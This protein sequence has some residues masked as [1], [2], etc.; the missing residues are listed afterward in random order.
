M[1][2]TIVNL[3]FSNP[4]PFDVRLEVVGEEREEFELDTNL[5]FCSDELG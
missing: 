1:S 2:R 4:W 5:V 3:L